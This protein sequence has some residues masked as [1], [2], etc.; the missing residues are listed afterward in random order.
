MKKFVIVSPRQGKGGPIVLHAMCK[1]LT[2]MGFDAKIFYT[3]YYK[4]E[5]HEKF[6]FW[7]RWFKYFVIDFFEKSIA[8]ILGEKAVKNSE[9]FARHLNIP[10]KGCKRK[11]LPWVDD[12]TIVVYPDVIYGNFLRAKHVVRWFLYHNRFSD[13]VDK[14]YGKNDMFVCYREIFNDDKLNPTRRKLRTPYFDWETYKQTNFGQRSGT[15]YIVRKGAKRPDLPE[16]FDGR[17][18]DDLSEKEKVKF[19]NQCE[20]CICYDLQTAYTTIAAVCGC[21]PIVIPEEGK[22]WRDYKDEGEKPL[23]V[24]WGTTPELIEYAKETR[25]LLLDK[26]ALNEAQGRETVEQFVQYCNEYFE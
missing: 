18:V 19:F 7:R 15:C 14:A 16:H 23:G 8:L 20:F 3:E 6:V 11:Y 9:R 4:Y 26:I 2:D 1:N 13:E 25:Q 12:D 24:A 10:V 5:E 21:I 17:V 22:T